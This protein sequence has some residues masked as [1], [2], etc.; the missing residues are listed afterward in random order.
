MVQSKDRVKVIAVG[1]TGF[2][3]VPACG[4]SAPIEPVAAAPDPGVSILVGRER[5]K[6]DRP[7]LAAARVI[8]PGVRGMGSGENFRLLEPLAD[9]L[10][11]AMGAS[12]AAVDA[13]CVPHDWEAGQTGKKC[14]AGCGRRAVPN[15]S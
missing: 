9:K 8:V 2:D 14:L 1:T 4:G 7:E 5:V 15:S 3:V 13:R 12:R 6:S 11:A 10:A